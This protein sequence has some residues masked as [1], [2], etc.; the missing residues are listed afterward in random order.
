MFMLSCL[1]NMVESLDF[2]EIKSEFINPF[3]N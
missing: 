2:V 1:K 3:R